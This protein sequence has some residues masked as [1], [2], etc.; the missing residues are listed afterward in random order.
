ME[1][2]ACIGLAK[3]MILVFPLDVKNQNELFG[4]LDNNHELLMAG[5]T[6]RGLPVTA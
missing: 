2:Q 3:K 6:Q 1:N 5:R 4:P